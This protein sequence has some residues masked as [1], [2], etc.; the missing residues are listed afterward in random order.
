MGWVLGAIVV[1]G[2]VVLPMLVAR[3]YRRDPHA[4]RRMAREEYD[5]LVKH[6]WHQ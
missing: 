1:L 6:L 5:S 3:R 4:V 2:L